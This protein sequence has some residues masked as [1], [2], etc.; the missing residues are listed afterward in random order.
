[1]PTWD[2]NNKFIFGGT[3]LVSSEFATEEDG[4]EDKEVMV[5]RG[6]FWERVFETDPTLHLWDDYKPV[7]IRVPKRKP[8]AYRI[9][10]MIV[11]HP[12]II[13]KLATEFGK[14]STATKDATFSMESFKNA[15]AKL[16]NFKWQK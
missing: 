13:E 3:K 14:F 10:D 7:I 11:A 1:M 15:V 9:Y 5:K 8:I 4:Y 6:G 16:E 12:I 2:Y